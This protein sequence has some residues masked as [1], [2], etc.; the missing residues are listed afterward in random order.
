MVRLPLVLLVLLAGCGDAPDVSYFP[1]REGLEWRYRVTET[2][3]VETLKRDYLVVSGE[4]YVAGGDTRYRRRND[5]GT[6]YHF[7]V[8]EDG[9]WR[10]GKRVI[11]ELEAQPDVPERL[12]MPIP[13]AAGR[14]WQSNTHPYVIR[15]LVSDGVDMR[16]AYTVPMNYTV[17]AIDAEVEV[18]AGTFE[19]C[20]HIV[21]EADLQMYVDGPSGLRSIPLR[22]DEWYARG[23]GLVR[24]RR[25]E[26]VESDLMASGELVMEL[27][28]FGEVAD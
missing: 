10:V 22:T 23:V 13:A 28:S 20:V 26:T 14:Q 5:G 2:S 3:S 21:G 25:V 7:R 19:R 11:V 18:P 8:G 9:V 27:E 15:R 1:L 6:E 12:V 16:R 24:L 17:A 4:P